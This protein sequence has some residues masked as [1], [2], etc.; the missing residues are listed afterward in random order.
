MKTKWMYAFFP[1]ETTFWGI[2][3]DNKKV[4]MLIRANTLCKI[5]EVTKDDRKGLRRTSANSRGSAEG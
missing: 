5:Q 2:N 3:I 1:K 4:E